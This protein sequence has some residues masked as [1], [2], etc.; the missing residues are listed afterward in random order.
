MEFILSTRNLLVDYSL[1]VSDS[2]SCIE[3]CR[4]DC[5]F[6]FLSFISDALAAVVT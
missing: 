4:F 6:F 2:F 5:F 3:L 1:V